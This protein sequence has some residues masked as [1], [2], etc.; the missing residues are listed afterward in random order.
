MHGNHHAPLRCAAQVGITS[1]GPAD[2]AGVSVQSSVMA[3]RGWLD[4]ELSKLSS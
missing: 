4:S 1:Y 2:C 3:L